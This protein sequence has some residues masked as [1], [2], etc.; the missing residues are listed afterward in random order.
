M[1]ESTINAAR[2]VQRL[3]SDKQPPNGILPESCGAFQDMVQTLYDAYHE[4]GTDHAIRTFNALTRAYPDVYDLC[5]IDIP[6]REPVRQE[7]VP[8]CPALPIDACLPDDIPTDAC[9]WLDT[10]VAFSRTWSPR[11]YD[12]FHEAIGLWLLSVIAARRVRLRYGKIGTDARYTNLYIA[13]CARTSVAAKSTTARIAVSVLD[14]VGLSHLLSPDDATPQAFIKALSADVPGNWADLSSDEREQVRVRLTFAAQRGWFFDEFGMKL[15]GM[16]RD[17]GTMADFRGLLRKFDDCPHAYSYETIQRGK[18]TIQQPYLALL[19]SLTP[20]DIRPYARSGGALWNDGFFARFAFVTPPATMPRAKGRFPTATN[21]IP[22]DILVPLR[23]WHDRLGVPDVQIDEI[24]N[25]DGTG[26]GRYTLHITPATGQDCTTADDVIDAFY[27]YH[28]AL[29]DI[30]AENENQDLDGNYA[31]FAEKAL[32]IATLFASLENDGHIDMKHWAKAQGIT[33]RWREN[34][35][36]LVS[37][38]HT[39]EPS[40]QRTVEDDVLRHVRKLKN[41]TAVEIG[42]YLKSVSVIEIETCLDGLA[43]SGAVHATRTAKSKRYTL[44][45]EEETTV[46]P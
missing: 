19:A 20:A 27:V 1:D 33:E 6:E 34:V 15:S 45:H 12:G 22:L 46:E 26:T 29:L 21:S 17:G 13:L 16:M 40:H 36:N 30:A 18:N 2:A 31:R 23:Q 43:R 42:R 9:P 41:P 44:I 5:N 8:T 28:D 11:S 4:G 32:R 35:H 37:Q 24:T 39:N 14:A 10:Y 3:I 7:L 25:N 38:M